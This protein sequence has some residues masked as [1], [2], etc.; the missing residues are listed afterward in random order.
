MS[1]HTPETLRIEAAP[2]PAST[3]KPPQTGAAAAVPVHTTTAPG[4]APVAGTSPIQAVAS[5]TL[6]RRRRKRSF[7]STF[8]YSWQL[9]AI[10]AVVG[11]IA[12]VVVFVHMG[13]SER[14][15]NRIEP[16]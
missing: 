16:Q 5:R 10:L 4:L 15:K 7:W 8:S 1:V 13:K 11:S 12:L 3:I 14:R 6:R 9:L 2:D